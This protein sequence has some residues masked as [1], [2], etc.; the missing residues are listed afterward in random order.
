MT[1]PNVSGP[2]TLF[3]SSCVTL[4]RF[5]IIRISRDR[6]VEL[7]VELEVVRLKAS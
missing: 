7:E 5:G 2:D 1:E 6:A 3:G 4:R